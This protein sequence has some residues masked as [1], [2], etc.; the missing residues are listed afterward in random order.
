MSDPVAT[1]PGSVFVD[2]QC[3][4][5]S[6]GKFILLSK[7]LISLTCYRVYDF[8]CKAAA[9]DFRC[10]TVTRMLQGKHSFLS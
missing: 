9:A 2:P 3:N 6:I 8:L 7:V 4:R 1:A 10:L 5:T